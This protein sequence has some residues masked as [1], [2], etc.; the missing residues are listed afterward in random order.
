M[1]AT[2]LIT[3]GMRAAPLFACS[4][5]AAGGSEPASHC[6]WFGRGMSEADKLEAEKKRLEE[7]MRAVREKL[8]VLAALDLN[9]DG[10]VDAEDAALALQMA[11]DKARLAASRRPPP[12]FRFFRPS[13]EERS[14]VLLRP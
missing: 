3:R 11:K 9:K 1:F 5:V 4:A 8:G 10:K 2:R 6:G 12:E 13:A 7:E 14:A